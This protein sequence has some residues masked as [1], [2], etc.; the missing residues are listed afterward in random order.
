VNLTRVHL[1]DVARN[2]RPEGLEFPKL[3]KAVNELVGLTFFD[4]ML[5]ISS[6]DALKSEYG[7]GGRGEEAFQRQLDMVLAEKVTS[8]GRFDL[9]E[10]IYQR[11]LKHPKYAAGAGMSD[12][13]ANQINLK[14]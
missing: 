4:T 10:S 12:F 8:S 1:D 6:N 5:K 3:R 13:P 14:A 11:I 2:A 9:G 7:H